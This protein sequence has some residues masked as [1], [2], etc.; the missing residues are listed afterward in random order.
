LIEAMVAPPCGLTH[1]R[2]YLVCA[3]LS[4]PT[5]DTGTSCGPD[6]FPAVM[7]AAQRPR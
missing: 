7:A 1:G 5:I 6:P 2:G 4:Y 3:S